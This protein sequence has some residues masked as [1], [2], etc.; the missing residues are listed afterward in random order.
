MPISKTEIHLACLEYYTLT[1]FVTP[2]PR[3]RCQYGNADSGT[4]INFTLGY[5]TT[6]RMGRLIRSEALAYARGHSHIAI[7][8]RGCWVS[9]YQLYDLAYWSGRCFSFSNAFTRMEEVSSCAL[10][11]VGSCWLLMSAGTPAFLYK[12]G[13]KICSRMFNEY[14]KIL[15]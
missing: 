4:I 8:A 15:K 10:V 14:A 13:M 3:F 2:S 5:S 7:F 11:L 9:Q 6:P 1:A 12:L